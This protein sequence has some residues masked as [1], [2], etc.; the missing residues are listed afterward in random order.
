M[1]SAPRWA[2]VWV[3]K[4]PA[5]AQVKSRTRTPLKGESDIAFSPAT[6]QLRNIGACVP[7]VSRILRIAQRP[8]IAPYSN[9][10]RL[11][12]R[13]QTLA[14]HSELAAEDL[15]AMLAEMRRRPAERPLGL[16]VL[17]GRARQSQLAHPRLIELDKVLAL[18]QMLALVHLLHRVD[19]GERDARLLRRLVEIGDLPSGDPLGHQ[20]LE[21]VH[22]LGARHPVLEDVFLC[23]L[24]IAHQLDQALP[25]MLFDREDEDFAVLAIGEK[26]RAE[27]TR[28]KARSLAPRVRPVHEIHLEHRGDRLLLAHVDR[29]AFARAQLVAHRGERSQRG[30]RAALEIALRA[31]G[32]ERRQFRVRRRAGAE[33]GPSPGIRGVQF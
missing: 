2:R 14:W 32:L 17:R 4:G 6:S 16:S 9:D 8:R 1:T 27:R 3:Q 5:H 24:W 7:R 13:G 10:A 30:M 23:P 21:R 33:I 28:S 26:P 31:E 18:L 15:L 11:F 20:R 25:L 19:R 29:L 12:K 22:V